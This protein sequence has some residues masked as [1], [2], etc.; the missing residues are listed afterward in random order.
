LETSLGKVGLFLSHLASISRLL[1]ATLYWIC[2]APFREH[3]PGFTWASLIRL[4][5]DTGVRSLPI[6]LLIGCLA[7]IIL[8]LETARQLQ[9]FGQVHLVAGLVALSMARSLGP[10]LT[11]IV[12]TGRV[13]AA[14]TA[15]LGTMKVSEEILAL[16]IMAVNPVGYLVAPRFLALVCMLPCLTIFADV[17][18]LVG[19]YLI[20]TTIWHIS[21]GQYINTTL[22]WL[23]LPDICAGLLK[24][25]VFA[26]IIGL[27]GCYRALVVEGGAEGVGQATMVSVVTTIVLII[28]ADGVFTAIL[29]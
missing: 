20:G 12:V 8:S 18:G 14:Y 28:V 13:G 24:S 17:M 10:L 11:A 25:V 16:E 26:V 5:Y 7:G 2:V 4:M 6:V 15:E 19:G 9:R 22:V 1:L 21:A 23:L 29:T 27:V 3:R